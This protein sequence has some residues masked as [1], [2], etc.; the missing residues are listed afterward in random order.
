MKTYHLFVAALLLSSCEKELELYSAGAG[1]N[2]YYAAPGDTLASYSFIYGSP[3]AVQDTVWLE[4]ETI[5]VPADR[6]RPVTIEQALTGSNDAQPGAHYIPFDDASLRDAYVV[7]AGQTRARVPVIVKRDASLQT[8][9]VTL[10]A[11]IKPNEEFPLVNPGRNRVKILFSDQLEKPESWNA[12]AYLFPFGAYGP[13]K[14]RF[15]IEQT[16]E[17]WDND[18]FIN[19][20]GIVKDNPYYNSNYDNAYCDYLLGVL[21][22]LLEEYNAGRPEPL[23]EADGTPVSF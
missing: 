4:L 11:R 12:S 6:D 8:R 10:L 14:H 21:R 13:V 3:T 7:T 22:R 17:K 15:M 19:V 20:L 5:G 23:K 18:Y 16:G 9:Q 1:L 2:F